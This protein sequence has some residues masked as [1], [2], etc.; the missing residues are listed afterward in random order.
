MRFCVPDSFSVS[1]LQ[2]CNSLSVLALGFG[3]ILAVFQGSQ[4]ALDAPPIGDCLKLPEAGRQSRSQ[5]HLRHVGAG[6]NLE[7]ITNIL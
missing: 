4:A 2:R 6:R 1:F 5:S 7:R 3:K